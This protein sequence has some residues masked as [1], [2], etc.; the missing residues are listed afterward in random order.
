MRSESLWIQIEVS[1]SYSL[2]LKGDEDNLPLVWASGLSGW[3]EIA[4]SRDYL[5]I[6]GTMF[7]GVCLFY[8]IDDAYQDA[9]EEANEIKKKKRQRA[10]TMDEI[11]ID[12][13][14]ILFQV[15]CSHIL[16]PMA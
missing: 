7:D 3:F 16:I 11:N 8:T 14:E 2:G 6:A 1:R 9:L 10:A 5:S 15:V 13:D 4:P 12:L